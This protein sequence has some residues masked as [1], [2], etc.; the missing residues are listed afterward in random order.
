MAATH[1]SFANCGGARMSI[2][3]AIVSPSIDYSAVR[4]V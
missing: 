3:E 2:V 1:F 4:L